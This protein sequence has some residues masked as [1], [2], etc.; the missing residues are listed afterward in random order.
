LLCAGC[1]QPL[2]EPVLELADDTVVHFADDA[3]LVRYGEIWRGN[4]IPNR[5]AL[6]RVDVTLTDEQRSAV[7]GIERAIARGSTFA[8][9]G[10]AGTGKTTVAAH[11]ALSRPRAILCAPTAKAASVLREKTGADASTVHAAFFAFVG[12]ENGVSAGAKIPH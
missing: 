8:L 11:V 7:A 4:T 3:C 12:Q 1:G 10:L 2:F 9:H 5:P 6:K